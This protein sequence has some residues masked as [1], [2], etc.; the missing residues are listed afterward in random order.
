MQNRTNLPQKV[1]L[2]YETNYLIIK[3]LI[4]H[5]YETMNWSDVV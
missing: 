5:S 2:Y 3:S 4:M 1:E